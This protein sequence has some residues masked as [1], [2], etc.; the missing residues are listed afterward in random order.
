V[1]LLSLKK[2]NICSY[3]SFFLCACFWYASH[4]R[5]HLRREYSYMHTNIHICDYLSIGEFEYL[6]WWL[7]GGI[8]SCMR[9]V[10]HPV[11]QKIILA[12]HSSF[13]LLSPPY[14]TVQVSGGRGRQ[15]TRCFEILSEFWLRVKRSYV[16]LILARDGVYNDVCIEIVTMATFR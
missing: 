9:F 2:V 6:L 5:V 13:P 11:T 4:S 3:K 16:L 15:R 7:G 10:A 14:C 1:L 12:V 8:G